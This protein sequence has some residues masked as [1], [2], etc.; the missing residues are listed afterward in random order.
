MVEN[1]SPGRASLTISD[2]AA[3]TNVSAATLRSWEERHGYPRPKRLPG[4]HRRYDAGDVA[5]VR[6]VIRRRDAGQTLASAIA[7]A[8]LNDDRPQASV[9]AALRRRHPHLVPHRV[10]KPTMLALTR[11]LEDESCARAESPVLFG[12]FQHGRFFEQSRHR[13]EELARTARATV[14]FATFAEP[15][16]GQDIHY[17]DLAPGS[18]LERE[19]L[20]VCDS[21]DHP[22]CAVSW[23]IPGSGSERDEDRWFEVLWSVEARVVRDAANI[24]AAL[25]EPGAL[26]DALPDEVLPIASDD[27]LRA[28]GLLE[29][30]LGYLDRRDAPLRDR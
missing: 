23:E 20:L 10:R 5:V 26:G 8:L 24:C 28:Q 9:F 4:G 13:W 27:L 17:V 19:W 3:A 30:T 14:V 1:N 11:A 2:L 15:P 18:P 25:L 21:E 12:G 16:A 29:R 6:D 22:G 7:A